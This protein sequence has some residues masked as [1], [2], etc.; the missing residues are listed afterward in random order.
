M[1]SAAPSSSDATVQL[2]V[3]AGMPY[4]RLGN[5]G[6]KVSRITLG[7][8]SYGSPQWREWVLDEEASLPFYRRALE[9]GINTFDT[10][11]LYSLG[12][13]ERV[14]GR[15]LRRLGT[16]RSDVVIMTKLYHYA[17]DGVGPN[18]RGLSRKH[19]FDAIDASLQRLGMDY[20]D[21]LQIHRWDP[22]C[23]F[24]EVMEALHDV[25][26]SGRVRYIGASSMYAWQFQQCQHIAEKRGWTKFISMQNHYNAV[27]REEE[28][29]MIPYCLFSGVGLIPWSPLARGFLCA[30]RAPTV[31]QQ[32]SD[33][34]ATVRSKTDSFAHDMYGSAADHEVAVRVRNL[35]QKRGVTPAQIALAWVLHRPGVNSPIIGATKMYQLEEAAAAVA[36]QLSA[37]E[38]KHIEEAYEPHCVLGALS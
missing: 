12:E 29:E 16:R 38:M 9:L 14:L 24:E 34:D 22:E 31:E 3:N 27:Y 25:V 10:A 17:G 8:M 20:V 37:D 19:I 36:I 4:V 33:A 30:P 13:S 28:R 32:K 26:K 21:V 18:S 11:D 2:N 23:S 15:C 7:C 5:S 1:S 35:A 6:L